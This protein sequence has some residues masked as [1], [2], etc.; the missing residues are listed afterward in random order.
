MTILEYLL[1]STNLI[2]LVVGTKGVSVF[3]PKVLKVCVKAVSI[4]QPDS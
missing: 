3:Q 2:F 4:F 1:P